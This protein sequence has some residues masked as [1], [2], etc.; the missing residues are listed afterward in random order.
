MDDNMTPAPLLPRGNRAP[1]WL[2]IGG[3]TVASVAILGFGVLLGSTIIPAFAAS[4]QGAVRT[5]RSF[6][7]GPQMGD[8]GPGAKGFGR[9]LSVTSVTASTIVAKDGHGNS[10]TITTSAS[11]TYTRAGKTIDRSAITAG[12]NISARGTRNSDGSITATAVEIVLP[13]YHGT[14]TAVN[15]GDIT[16]HDAR[17]NT[18]HI[19]HTDAATTFMRAG[20]TSSLS[21]ITTGTQISAIGTLNS[22]NSLKAEAVSIQLPHVGGQITKIS[23]NDITVQQRGGTQVIHVSGSTTYTSITVTS[24]G[25]TKSTA[26]LSDL[27]VGGF[28]LAEGTKNSD[29]TLN[30]EAV[31]LLPAGGL[32]HGK[33]GPPGVAH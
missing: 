2:L 5:Q 14:V 27:K 32:G 12:T 26:S 13:G 22:D 30:A 4:H 16:V 21:A 25:P 11:T 23:G 28:I 29:G 15:G 19:I 7:Q 1:R 20:A 3:A 24:S 9:S 10:V 33:W 8:H 17:A 18:T 6:G 31:T